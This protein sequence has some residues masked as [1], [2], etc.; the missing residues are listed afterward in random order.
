[1]LKDKQSSALPVIQVG[2]TMNKALLVF[3]QSDGL[4]MRS[5]GF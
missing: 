2:K 3:R 1:M 5:L 4:A